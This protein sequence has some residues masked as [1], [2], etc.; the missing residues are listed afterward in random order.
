MKSVS[1]QISDRMYWIDSIKLLAISW[2]FFTHFCVSARDSLEI[3]FDWGKYG[4]WLLYG[5]TGKYAVAFFCV[6]LGYF[7]SKSKAQF[8][9]DRVLNRYFQFCIPLLIV[10]SLQYLFFFIEHSVSLRE[11]I[12]IPRMCFLFQSSKLC[13]PAWCMPFFFTASIIIYLLNSKKHRILIMSFL[14]VLFLATDLIWISICLFGALIHYAAQLP[15]VIRALEKLNKHMILFSA[16]KILLLVFSYLIIRFPENNTTYIL[17]GISASVVFIVCLNSEII[18]KVLSLSSMFCKAGRYSFEIFLL[19][20]FVYLATNQYL[21]SRISHSFHPTLVFWLAFV[22]AYI[23]TLICAYG[24]SK[25][26]NSKNV[27]RIYAYVKSEN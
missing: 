7:A 23:F 24:L 19:H 2:I 21:F 5:I 3:T 8:S 15:F 12:L 18:Q 20:T 10:S 14:A 6:I 9:S 22:V 17:D 16:I 4:S 13:S 26:I 25:L 1:N 11:I 27:K